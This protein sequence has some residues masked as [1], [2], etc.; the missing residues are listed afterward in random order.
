MDL[1]CRVMS[2]RLERI[3]VLVTEKRFSYGRAG[4]EQVGCEG[5]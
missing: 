4:Q 1:K 5:R 2:E 3:P